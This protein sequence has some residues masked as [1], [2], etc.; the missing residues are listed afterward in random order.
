MSD[1]RHLLVESTWIVDLEEASR[2]SFRRSLRSEL[3][4]VLGSVL[5]DLLRRPFGWL[6]QALR[7]IA[8]RPL[9]RWRQR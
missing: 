5:G 9:A 4:G 3:R 2:Q 1:S 7:R 6:W 8:G